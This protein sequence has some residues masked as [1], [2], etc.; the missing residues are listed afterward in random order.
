MEMGLLPCSKKDF[1]YITLDKNLTV[2]VLIKKRKENNNYYAKC[3]KSN[4]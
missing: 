4:K 1:F 3:K 2:S